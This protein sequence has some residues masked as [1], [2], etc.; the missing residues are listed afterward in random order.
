VH[1]EIKSLSAQAQTPNRNIGMYIP[2]TCADMLNYPNKTDSNLAINAATIQKNSCFMDLAEHENKNHTVETSEDMDETRL[3]DSIVEND[4]QI[5]NLNNLHL[6][7][8][9]SKSTPST[10]SPQTTQETQLAPHEEEVV[11]EKSVANKKININSPVKYIQGKVSTL[12]E[13][14]EK[15][16]VL[17]L[18]TPTNGVLKSSSKPPA[19]S[20][21]GRSI[22]S[23]TAARTK[24]DS[25]VNDSFDYK[26]YKTLSMSMSQLDIDENFSLE[27]KHFE[28][29]NLKPF[30]IDSV[31][32][33]FFLNK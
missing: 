17:D 28:N 12:V 19:K 14:P 15:G 30:K 6:N 7:Q 24:D 11:K 27:S 18:T 16:F 5:K 31:S 32:L 22:G 25:V 29:L 3:D 1:H 20:S 21:I 9:I 23:T 33:T 26:E 4:C 2:D 8:V 13:S 10:W